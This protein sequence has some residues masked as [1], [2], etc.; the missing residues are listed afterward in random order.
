MLDEIRSIDV[1]S[2]A[3]RG[4]GFLMGTIGLIVAVWITWKSGWE[5]T[6]AALLTAVSGAAVAA[7]GLVLPALLRPVYRLWMMLAVVLGFVMTRVILTIVYYA[8]VT[9]IGLA[10]R[11]FGRD[12]LAKRPDPTVDSYWIPVERGVETP[13]ESAERLRR[14]Y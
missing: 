10:M 2:R 4:F 13:A 8:V 12:P 3:V 14:Y 6:R 9:P 11:A 1:S 7:L 5:P